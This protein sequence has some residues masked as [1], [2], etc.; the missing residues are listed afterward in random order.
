MW[1]GPIVALLVGDRSVLMLQGSVK[2]TARSPLGQ[3]R[4]A[5]NILNWP[6]VKVSL[7]TLTAPASAASLLLFEC[8]PTTSSF[9]QQ[10]RGARL[11]QHNIHCSFVQMIVQTLTPLSDAADSYFAYAHP[12]RHC[13]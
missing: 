4:T 9:W 1:E 6:V 10:W 5:A 8:V 7:L 2:A 11:L 12:R 13:R 3:L